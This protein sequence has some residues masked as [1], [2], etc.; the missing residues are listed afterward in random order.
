MATVPTGK[1]ERELRAYYLQWVKGLD[2]HSNDLPGYIAQFGR[3]ANQLINQHGGNVARLAMDAGFPAP[4]PLPL[5]FNPEHAIAEMQQAAIAAGIAVGQGAKAQASAMLKAGMDSAYYRLERRARTETVSAYWANQWKQV[6][7]LGMEMQWSS[8]GGARTCAFCKAKDGLVVTDP[9][10]RDHPNGRCTLQPMFPKDPSDWTFKIPEGKPVMPLF[11]SAPR[12]EAALPAGLEPEAG[13]SQAWWQDFWGSG[14]MMSPQGQ[15][16][17]D[18]ADLQRFWTDPKEVERAHRLPGPIVPK[19]VGG[20]AEWMM[21]QAK[22]LKR[23]LGLYRG[24]SVGLPIAAGTVRTVMPP[25]ATTTSLAEAA[26][27]L[28]QGLGTIY[29]LDAPRGTRVLLGKPGERELVLPPGYR[30]R[31]VSVSQ[32]L[33]DGQTVQ[34]VRGQLLPPVVGEPFYSTGTYKV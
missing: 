30:I 1:M 13:T 16:P 4:K 3:R 23:G 20:M 28:G 12:K 26:N 2:A 32:E 10:L 31:V 9:T 15:S 11:K 25:V 6:E 33:I 34:V 17:F 24:E 29:M 21:Q 5:S 7:G 8:E 18:G 19:T 14:K 22:P 27:H